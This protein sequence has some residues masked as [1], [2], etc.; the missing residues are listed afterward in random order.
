MLDL[1][2]A[3]RRVAP[4]SPDSAFPYGLTGTQQSLHRCPTPGAAVS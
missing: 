1:H 2:M 3:D 4:G